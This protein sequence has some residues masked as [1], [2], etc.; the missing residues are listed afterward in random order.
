MTRF[1]RLAASLAI[2]FTGTLGFSLPAFPAENPHPVHSS[3]R[4]TNASVLVLVDIQNFYFPGGQLPLSGPEAAAAHAATL[5]TRFRELGWPVIHVQH[6]PQDQKVPTPESGNPQYQIHALVRPVP[7]DSVI[8]KHHANAFRDTA[9]LESL[10]SLG[11]RKLLVAGMQTHMCVEA[12]ARAAA[13]LGFEVVVPQDACATRTLKFG[14]VEVSAAQV[15]ASTLA[16]LQ[17]SY[18]TV[19]ASDDVLKTLPSGP[20][21]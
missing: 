4:G 20:G 12:T 2:V 11:A 18:A 14:E 19:M 10:R 17:G 21:R 5:L 15:H 6:L 13:D 9:L 1:H 8:G 16:S 3:E 7:G